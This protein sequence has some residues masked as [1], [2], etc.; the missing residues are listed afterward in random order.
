MPQS[1]RAPAQLFAVTPSGPVPLPVPDPDQADLHKLMLRLP[2]GVYSALRTFHHER[3]L[4]LDE[5]VARTVRSMRGLG[6]DY[7]LDC[8]ALR[9]A[10]QRVARD[11]PGADSRVRFDVLEAPAPPLG[12]E[13]RVILGIGAFEPVPEK[14]LREGVQVEIAAG[15]ERHEPRIKTTEF[16][17]RRQPYPLAQQERY[18]HLLL[19]HEQRILE[20]SSSNFFGVERGGLRTSGPGVLEGITRKVLV[21]IARAMGIAIDERALPLSAVGRLDEAF[22]SSSTRGVVPIVGVAGA[23]IGDGRPGPLTRRLMRAYDEF[24]DR[25]ARPAV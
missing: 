20:G 17:L 2:A 19:D 13:S 24:A 23:R 11:W 4:W 3:F 5:H 6:W 15:L 10:L 7:E 12:T 1:T 14:Y 21:H 8:S 18:E 9:R 25:E 22:L 16:I